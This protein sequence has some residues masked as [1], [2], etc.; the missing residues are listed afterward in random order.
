IQKLTNRKEKIEQELARLSGDFQLRQALARLTPS[1]L[2]AT[3]PPGTA[4][5]DLLEYNHFTP[6]KKGKS[7]GQSE[8]RVLAFVLRHGQADI[9]AIALGRA[10]PISAAV[11]RWRSALEARKDDRAGAAELRRLVW[12]PLE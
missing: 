2:R 7:R 4:L 3:L 6:P 11:E 8:R 10:E 1:Q 5:V 12:Q 9:A